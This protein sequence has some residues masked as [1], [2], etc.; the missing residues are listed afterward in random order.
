MGGGSGTGSRYNHSRKGCVMRDRRT[1]QHR[2]LAVLVLTVAFVAGAIS[3]SFAI[4]SAGEEFVYHID[5]DDITLDLEELHGWNEETAR[6]EI[7]KRGVHFI[8][9]YNH[10]QAGVVEDSPYYQVIFSYTDYERFHSST[11]GCTAI[12]RAKEGLFSEPFEVVIHVTVTDKTGILNS[13]PA[14][15]APV[16][17]VK[18]EVRVPERA[19]R[20]FL[21]GRREKKEA[22]VPVSEVAEEAEVPRTPEKSAVREAK[23]TET[24]WSS[25]EKLAV[26]ATAGAG[27]ATTALLFAIASDVKVLLWYRARKRIR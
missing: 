7:L 26:A 6:K 18:P 5:S 11:D 3:F 19:S 16:L 1:R 23:Q 9:F 2:I 12:L 8:G 17:P 27:L 22:L 10:E 4:P 14:E 13:T 21:P 15:P 24:G 20:S 25:S